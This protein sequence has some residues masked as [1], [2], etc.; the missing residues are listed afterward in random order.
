M[1]Q[2]IKT[3]MSFIVRCIPFINRVAPETHKLVK[4]IEEL[5]TKEPLS[6][7]KWEDYK[8]KNKIN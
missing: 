2:W 3:I 6:S 5:K 7:N 1:S 8:R 4:E